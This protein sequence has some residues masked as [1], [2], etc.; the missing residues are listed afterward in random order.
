MSQVID[1]S[2]NTLVKVTDGLI[3]GQAAHDA[4]VSGNPVLIGGEARSTDG[5]AIGASGRVVRFL[6]SLLG[7]LVNLP[8]ALPG[9]SWSYAAASGGI[10][11][12]TGVT[13]KAA[14]GGVS[15]VF[16]PPLRGTVNTLIEVKC[17]TTGSATYFNL[18]GFSAAE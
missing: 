6:L 3:Q 2:G 13:A 16:D 18:Q 12:T 8:Y 1:T 17:G 7:K 4:A 14:G 11:N 10:T 9:S 15:A 5:T